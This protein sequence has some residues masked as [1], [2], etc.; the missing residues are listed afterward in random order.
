[1]QLNMVCKGYGF[2]SPSGTPH[3]WYTYMTSMN[4]SVGMTR[5]YMINPCVCSYDASIRCQREVA[6]CSQPMR[7][8]IVSKMYNNIF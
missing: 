4:M 1:M 6:V 2:Q 5:N 3:A 8:E 7:I